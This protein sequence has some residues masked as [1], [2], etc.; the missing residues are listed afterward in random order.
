MKYT[1]AIILAIT[2]NISLG[3]EFNYKSV[4]SL[5]NGENHLT[6][7]KDE[8][9][10][11]RVN[12]DTSEVSIVEGRIFNFYSVTNISYELDC[13]NNATVN[14]ELHQGDEVS[15]LTIYENV[16]YLYFDYVPDETGFF[17]SAS[18]RKE[19]SKN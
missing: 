19:F 13:Q 5:N 16:M 12:K 17:L 6:S 9:I 3:Q 2:L 15:T 11:V 1:I 4:Y 7:S 14:L 10:S 18:K 8:Y